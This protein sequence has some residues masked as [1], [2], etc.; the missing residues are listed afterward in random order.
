MT[1]SPAAKRSA[2]LV[3]SRPRRAGYSHHAVDASVHV[4]FTQTA[5][6]EQ[7]G[8]DGVP[9]DAPSATSTTQVPLSQWEE[10]P[11]RR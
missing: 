6:H 9:H 8:P 4:P 10:A 3:P 2:T 7:S 11:H 5:G 1:V